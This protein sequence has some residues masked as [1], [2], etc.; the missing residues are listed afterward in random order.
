[1]ERKVLR[2][3][4]K[5][6]PPPKSPSRWSARTS[7][8]VGAAF[9]LVYLTW[10]A[11]TAPSACGVFNDDA[12]CLVTAKAMADGHG[13]R[14]LDLPSEPHQ[15]K[16]PVLYPFILSLVWRLW[17][18][19][20]AN[21]GWLRMP[22]VVFS[23][24]SVV[25]GVAYAAR[26][27]PLN[28]G[29]LVL[30]AL[31][32]LTLP[33]LRLYSYFT[34]S[35][36]LFAVLVIVALELCERADTA[37][38]RRSIG[39]AALCGLLVG[40]AF[41]AR[42][43]GLTLLVAVVAWLLYRR[44]FAAAAWSGFIGAAFVVGCWA[45]NHQAVAGDDM[46]REA[47]LLRYDLDYSAW[48]PHSVAG[49]C[50]VLAQN[51]VELALY[52]FLFIVRLPL[53]CLQSALG[54]CGWALVLLH[55]G[56]WVSLFVTLVGYVGSALTRITAAHVFVPVYIGVV[57][58]W[59][60]QPARFLAPIFVFVIGFQL[61]GWSYTARWISRRGVARSMRFSVGRTAAPIVGLVLVGFYV[62][63]HR[64][65]LGFDGSVC[66]VL[67]QRFDLAEFRDMTEQVRNHVPSDAV[68]ASYR[69]AGAYLATGRKTVALFPDIDPVAY[70]YSASRRW[71][72][73]CTNQPIEEIERWKADALE[74]LDRA[75]REIGVRYQVI[76]TEVPA[77]TR[78]AVYAQRAAFPDNYRLVY[79]SPGKSVVVYE[80]LG[81][82]APF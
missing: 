22:G 27:L 68:V 24:A 32:C 37:T 56:V 80:L 23:V 49:T 21:L 16:Y 69:S 33:E 13:Y 72:T 43:I 64:V 54:D 18:E 5:T 10:T 66:N 70:S 61:L 55:A 47:A 8:L 14:R 74:C 50:C 48:L 65:L 41:L 78:A 1:M 36:P 7:L 11:F 52:N 3:K 53:R 76:S 17:G 81:T 35:E 12:V 34:M 46:L 63:H 30:L 29:G 67:A 71:S 9:L 57:L 6:K 60:F 45:W 62:A 39:T 58:L 20:P 44:R 59:P 4:A 2:Q 79:I 19:F 15:T 73:F 51:F 38:G 77:G 25:L 26:R 42:S 82:Q 31:L 75:Y 40:L 28:R